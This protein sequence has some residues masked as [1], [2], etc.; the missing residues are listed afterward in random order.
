MELTGARPIPVA[1]WVRIPDLYRDPYAIYQR[2]RPGAPVHWVPAVNRYLVVGYQACHTVEQD[3]ERF[4]ANE[5]GSLMKRAMGHGVL[6]RDDPEHAVERRSYGG[7][8][9]PKAFKPEAWARAEQSYREVDDAIDEMLPYLREHPGAS[10]LSALSG[11][12]VPLEA[13][14]ANLKMTIGGGLNEPRDAIGTTAWALLR[15]PDQLAQVLEGGRWADAFEESIR[16]VAPIGMYPREA[17]T[18]TALDGVLVPR[19]A[20]L[21]IVVGAAN[22]DPGVFADPESYDIN[23]E[24]RPHLA[25]GG[26]NHFC[27]GAWVARASFVGVALPKLFAELPGLRL[28]PDASAVAGGWVFRGMLSLPVRWG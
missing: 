27:A 7:V 17:T 5:T 9:R 12:P 10:L 25:F 2:L 28:D 14:R 15:H 22:R 8:L 1:G 23:R 13:V 3:Q 20:R 19:G 4:S 6:R 16:W 18:D 21:G 11:L 26:G 24:R